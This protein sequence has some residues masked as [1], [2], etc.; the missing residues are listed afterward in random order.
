MFLSSGLITWQKDL[1]I[2]SPKDAGVFLGQGMGIVAY[3]DDLLFLG[4]NEEEIEAVTELQCNGFQLQREKNGDDS[5]YNFLGIHIEVTDATIQMTHFGLI[6]K[7]LNLVNM[8]M[9]NAK[10]TPCS[11]TPLYSDQNGN[12][13]QL[14]VC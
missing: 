5:V 2:T 1:I 4:P 8:E 9:S 14:L 10:E 12:I 13:P 7:N 6:R 11:T 3:V